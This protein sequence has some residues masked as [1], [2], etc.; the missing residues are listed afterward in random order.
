MDLGQAWIALACLIFPSLLVAL[1]DFP[2]PKDAKV[3][4]VGNNM[5][6]N[7]ISSDIRAFY[8]KESFEKVSAFYREKWQDPVSGG[9]RDEE[10]PGYSETDVMIPWRLFTRIEDGYLMTVQFQEADRKGVW[11]YLAVS[12][13][14]KDPGGN[15][16]P[17]L[18]IPRDIPVMG[19]SQIISELVNEDPGQHGRTMIIYNTHSVGSNIS[20]Y[21]HHYLNRGFSVDNDISL[22]QGAMHSL[23]FKS[24]RK[25]INIMVIGGANDT[26]VVINAVTNSIF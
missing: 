11:G 6:L 1:P 3:E 12:R 10:L 23:V 26:R 18:A 4:I 21:R 13:L 25:R 9:E 16:N 2:P 20:F 24:S 19:D 17:V 7:G 5:V 22:S 14:P 8:T 15:Q